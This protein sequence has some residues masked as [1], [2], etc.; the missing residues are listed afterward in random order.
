[1][2]EDIKKLIRS[3]FF[4][5]ESSH[6]FEVY[7]SS[8]SV[9]PNQP[10]KSLEIPG[11]TRAQRNSEIRR[12]SNL[13]ENSSKKLSLTSVP[14]ITKMTRVGIVGFGNLGQFLY[15]EL[16]KISEVTI[17]FVW[18]RTAEKM[19]GIVP[20]HQIL[21]NLDDLK[22]VKVDLI[23]EVTHPDVLRK[24]AENFTEIADLFIGSPTVLSNKDIE[25]TI[26][27]G[28]VTAN[29][30]FFSKEYKICLQ[31]KFLFS[32]LF[33]VDV[34]SVKV[35]YGALMKLDKWPKTRH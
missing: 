16:V 17:V 25:A 32:K 23:I 2:K 7:R 5:N 20:N 24:Y 31:R 33:I 3:S 28:C 14:E 13:S 10:K 12:L 30:E 34:S 29:L 26:R 27:N 9:D 6:D 21:H 1:M 11:Q 19:K 22:G 8:Y 35:L 18:N 15:E 4:K